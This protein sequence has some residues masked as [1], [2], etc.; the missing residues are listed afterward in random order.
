M[1]A[2]GCGSATESGHASTE[3]CELHRGLVHFFRQVS[4]IQQQVSECRHG[5]LNGKRITYR[6]RIVLQPVYLFRT[7]CK[8]SDCGIDT[9]M[10]WVHTINFVA[11][12]EKYKNKWDG[13]AP[14]NIKLV[15]AFLL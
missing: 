1:L 8:L 11:M 6:S 7:P 2:G 4:K 15:L 10:Y 12:V 3:I 13:L 9:G 5:K 14:N